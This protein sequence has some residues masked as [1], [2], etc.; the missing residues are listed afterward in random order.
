MLGRDHAGVGKYYAK[1]ESQKL[2][3][4]HEKYLK[5]KIISFKE[6]YLCTS[7]KKVVNKCYHKKK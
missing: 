5:V 2:C 7:C 4:K 1:Y 3:I 6:P